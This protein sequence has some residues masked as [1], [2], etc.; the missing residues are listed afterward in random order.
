MDRDEELYA[1]ATMLDGYLKANRTRIE[2]II[3]ES[4]YIAIKETVNN[5]SAA[6]KEK[7]ADVIKVLISTKEDWLR[8]Q[9]FQQKIYLKDHPKSNLQL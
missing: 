9:D 5:M 1:A 4:M 7:K 2:P 3:Q 8:F 6:Y